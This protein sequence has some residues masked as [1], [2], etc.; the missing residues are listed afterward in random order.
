MTTIK[1]LTT[2]LQ[3]DRLFL[4]SIGEGHASELYELFSDP[5]LHRF[6]PF[7]VPS[8]EE[9]KKR[10]ARWAIGHSPDGSEIYLNWAAREKQLG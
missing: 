8:L 2:S 6:V 7:E 5:E 10:C 4:E 1:N 9:Q 3:T